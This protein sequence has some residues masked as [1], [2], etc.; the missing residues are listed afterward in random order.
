MLLRLEK[1]PQRV[2]FAKGILEARKQHYRHL[3]SILKPLPLLAPTELELRLGESIRVTL[4]DAN[5]CPGAVMF[6][7]EGSGKAVLYTGDVRAEPWWVNA[8]SRSPVMIPFTCGLQQLDC[9]YLDTTFATH[10]SIYRHFPTKEDG[11]K[12][13]LR[14]IHNLPPETVFYFRAWTLGYEDVWTALASSLRTTVHV[15]PYQIL[16]YGSCKDDVLIRNSVSDSDSSALVGFCAGNHWHPGLLS[17]ET[18]SRIHSCEP[19]LACHSELSKS[20]NIVWITPIIS[21]RP[22]GTEIQ[23]VGAGGGWRD[24]H[25]I[26]EIDSFDQSVSGQLVAFCQRLI[27][28]QNTLDGVLKT[29]KTAVRQRKIPLDGLTLDSDAE[30]TIQEVIES[31]SARSVPNE[32]RNHGKANAANNVIH[33]PYSRHSS[34]GELRNLVARFKPKDICPCTVDLDSWSEELSMQFLFSDICSTPQEWHYDKLNR[35]ASSKHQEELLLLGKRKRDV[36]DAEKEDTQRTTSTDTDDGYK[37]ARHSFVGGKGCMQDDIGHLASDDEYCAASS[38]PPVALTS[39]ARTSQDGMEAI[40]ISLLENNGSD[41]LRGTECEANVTLEA[42]EHKCSTPEKAGRGAKARHEDK[43]GIGSSAD[44]ASK[45][46]HVYSTR[47]TIA[48]EDSQLSLDTSAF[49]SQASSPAQQH[50]QTPRLDGCHSASTEDNR[51][52]RRYA[53]R[54]AWGLVGGSNG[55]DDARTAWTKWEG[56]GSIAGMARRS[57]TE[58]EEDLGTTS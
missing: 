13:L 7:I 34:Y 56:L 25:Q 15:D 31:L 14:K 51:R 1:Y 10:Q 4:L 40:K 38:A 20:D 18:S 35:K 42:G 3:K 54:A 23:E 44:G 32:P 9:I 26:P 29:L 43:V 28:D 41:S 47:P 2:N 50:N 36:E 22:D 19:G 57:H 48:D 17:L 45:E 6:L 21:R 16:L 49:D 27:H 52:A 37:T 12:E 24:L 39:D 55:P 8:I 46:M 58:V 53:Y 5:H 30:V 33:F 11:L